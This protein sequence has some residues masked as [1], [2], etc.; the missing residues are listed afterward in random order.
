MIFQPL[1]ISMTVTVVLCI[2]LVT[3]VFWFS[4]W[5]NYYSYP[6]I[7][8]S[9]LNYSEKDYAEKLISEVRPEY[10][11]LSTNIIFTTNLSDLGNTD[12]TIARYYNYSGIA[13]IGNNR[14]AMK[15]IMIY[16]RFNKL[17]DEH[18]ICH[19]LLH[20]LCISSQSEFFVDDLA[21]RRVC[22]E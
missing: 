5:N 21:N 2:L 14:I 1:K 10:I 18:V 12:M 13:T 16:L 15:K 11:N 20:S 19:E 22:Y 4:Y 7:D 6:K 9:R 3:L 8:Y 17:D